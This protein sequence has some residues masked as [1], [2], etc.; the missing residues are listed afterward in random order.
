MTAREFI[1]LL[2]RHWLLLLLIP[3]TTAGSI[4][5]FSRFQPK[6]YTSDTVIYTAIGSGYKIEGGN[7]GSGDGWSAAATAFDNILTLINSRD[8]RQEVCLRLVAWRLMED[9]ARPARPAPTTTVSSLLGGWGANNAADKASAYERLLPAPLRAR[10]TGP[11]LAVTTTRVLAYYRATPTNPLYRLINS[12][13]PQFSEEAL[14]RINASRV[15]DSDLV[16]IEYSASDPVVCQKTLALLTDVFIRKH[17][18]LFTGQNESVIGYFDQAAQKGFQRLQAAEQRLLAFHQK[19]NIVDYDEQ[20]VASTGDRQLTLDKYNALQMQYAG[21]TSSLKSVESTLGKRGVSNLKSQE[22][23]RLRDRLSDLNRQITEVELLNQAQSSPSTAGRL[24]SL[25]QEAAQ[26]SGKIGETVNSYYSSSNATQGVAVKDLATDYTKNTLLVADLRSQLNLM[27]RQQEASASQY[28]RLVPLGAEIRKLRREVE[29]AE[30]EYLSQMEGV[31]QS[32]LSQQNGVL[33][34]QLR[35]VDPPYLPLDPN[36]SKTLLLMVGGFLGSFLLI[37]A[38]LVTTGMLDNSL[39]QPAVATKVTTFPVAG[40]LA[41]TVG[42]NEQQQLDAKR[43][44]DHLGRQLLLKLQQRS[45]DKPYVIGVLS[46]QSGEGKTAVCD[47]L[48]A[49]LRAMHI[50]TL[51]LFPGYHYFLQLNYDDTRFYSP[52]LG[53]TP[54]ST[55]ADFTGKAVTLDTV[56]IIE[57]PALLESAYPASLLQ[58]LD[59]ILVA[60]RADRAW[61]Q[62]DKTIFENIKRI[63][64]SPIELVLNGVLPEYVTDFIGK[65]ARPMGAYRGPALPAHPQQALLN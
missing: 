8:T 48:T 59:L 26:L 20:I 30:K 15:K 36:G 53:L 13:D 62:A 22:I 21:A 51:T 50:K 32:K 49:S 24:A 44:E 19:H 6:N 29:V 27:R 39:Q 41:K 60:V 2:R 17:R 7:N 37:G 33:A 16:R 45:P 64:R 52:L 61:H 14:W 11:T 65:Q 10:L 31:K 28:N 38:G 40:I 42:L 58:E 12:K 34:S 5:V 4:Y 35:V 9:A 3:V 25:K 23:I 63:T 43:A 47:S 57:F 46:S 1:R 55:I 54:G 56:V 18:E